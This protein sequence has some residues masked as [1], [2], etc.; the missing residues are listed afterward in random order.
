MDELQSLQLALTAVLGPVRK[1]E[2]QLA[3]ETLE[4]EGYKSLA[5]RCRHVW[6]KWNDPHMW[7]PDKYQVTGT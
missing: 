6:R 4:R 5:D 3:I 7:R 1:H 2:R